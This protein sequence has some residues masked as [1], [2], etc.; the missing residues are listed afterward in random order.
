[1]FDQTKSQA[2]HSL[3][4]LNDKNKKHCHNGHP[5]L[6]FWNVYS[7]FP[8]NDK[9]K[10]HCHNGHPTLKCWNTLI[11]DRYIIAKQNITLASVL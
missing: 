3:F 4:T 5:M 2:C 11:I 1:M 7:I 9:D 10:K 6:K 8:L